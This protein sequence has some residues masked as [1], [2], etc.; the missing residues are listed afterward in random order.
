MRQSAAL[1]S[2]LIECTFSFADFMNGLFLGLLLLGCIFYSGAVDTNSNKSEVLGTDSVFFDLCVVR[3][4]SLKT[5][6]EGWLQLIFIAVKRTNVDWGEV[7]IPLG[8]GLGFAVHDSHH[9]TLWVLHLV[10]ITSHDTL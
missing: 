9:H 7:K 6:S 5:T 4:S 8:E 2:S 10:D 3:V 1:Q